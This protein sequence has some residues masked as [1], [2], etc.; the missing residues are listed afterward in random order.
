MGRNSARCWTSYIV[1]LLLLGCI[2][3]LN[4]L[5]VSWVRILRSSI[6]FCARGPARVGKVGNGT[7]SK[8]KDS[9]PTSGG[10]VMEGE[11]RPTEC[12]Y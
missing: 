7:G 8:L 9:G 10:A 12:T 2:S 4:N 6:A 11:E 3:D 5:G 1:E